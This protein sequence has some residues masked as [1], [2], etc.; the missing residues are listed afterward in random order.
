MRPGERLLDHGRRREVRL[1]EPEM[2]HVDSLLARAPG[3]ARR[4]RRPGTARSLAVRRA[5]LIADSVPGAPPAGSA[6]ACRAI[7]EDADL[8]PGLIGPVHGHL[9]DAIAARPARAAAARR[10][11]RIPAVAER[12][13]QRHA[14]RRR[15]RLEATLRVGDAAEPDAGRRAELKMRPARHAMRAA[16]GTE[17]PGSGEDAR[18]DDHVGAGRQQPAPAASARRSASRHR[19]RR[20]GGSV[21]PRSAS[22]PVPP[23]PCRGCR[24]EPERA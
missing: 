3:P 18:A 21:P 23:R 15:E 13:E 24:P 5:R 17:T 7:G 22:P 19:H 14:A 4:P 9:D 11:S 10:R 12:A 6:T 1:A 8:A 20:R 2:H 16:S